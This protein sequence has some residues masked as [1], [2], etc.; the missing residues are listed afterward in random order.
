MME[1][2]DSGYEEEEELEFEINEI[3]N[4]VNVLTP[5]NYYLD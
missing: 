2:L 3:M 5:A 1:A 4:S